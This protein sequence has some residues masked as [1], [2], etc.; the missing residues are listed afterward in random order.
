[1]TAVGV[2]CVYYIPE[3]GR[4]R[5]SPISLNSRQT[6]PSLS[7]APAPGNSMKHLNLRED[8]INDEQQ[9]TQPDSGGTLQYHNKQWHTTTPQHVVCYHHG[10]VYHK[11]PNTMST[12]TAET[13]EDRPPHTCAARHTAES[14]TNQ[15]IPYRAW[16][17]DHIFRVSSTRCILRLIYV[18]LP[19]DGDR[20]I[21]VRMYARRIT[22]CT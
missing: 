19:R 4:T 22:D 10:R 14:E 9:T 6:A 3:R 5:N 17:R 8:G 7:H 11:P 13:Q 16:S 15:A 20:L 1:M 2:W 18:S 12:Y 21:D